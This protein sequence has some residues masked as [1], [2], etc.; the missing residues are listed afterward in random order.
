MVG[1]ENT[2]RTK[3]IV[4]KSNVRARDELEK[5]FFIFKTS[6]QRMFHLVWGAWNTQKQRVMLLFR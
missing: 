5:Q 4:I 6:S 2:S 3:E 1:D